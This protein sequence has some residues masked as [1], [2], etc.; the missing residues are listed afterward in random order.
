MEIKINKIEPETCEIVHEEDGRITSIGFANEYEFNDFRIQIKE[1]GAKGYFVRY[2]D[3]LFP[4][5][6]DGR[7]Y[8]P[9]GLF[10]LMAEQLSKLLCF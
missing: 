6:K 4:I 9:K 7:L 10:E 1:S 5:D 2:E 3:N 8:Y